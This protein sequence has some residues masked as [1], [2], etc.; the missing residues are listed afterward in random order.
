MRTSIHTACQYTYIVPLLIFFS[1]LYLHSTFLQSTI[2]LHT[3][4]TRSQIGNILPFYLFSRSTNT[5]GLSNQHYNSFYILAPTPPFNLGRSIKLRSHFQTSC[6]CQTPTIDRNNDDKQ[7]AGRGSQKPARLTPA[8][9]TSR[10]REGT[11]V[12]CSAARS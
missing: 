10:S 8:T 6:L 11:H 9:I 4:I 5:T 12:R 1:S 3:P 2:Y 7:V